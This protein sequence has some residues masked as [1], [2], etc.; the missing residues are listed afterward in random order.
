[1][2]TEVSAC[3]HIGS[4]LEVGNAVRRACGLPRESSRSV[5]LEIED[6][7]EGIRLR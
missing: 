2:R 4:M 3:Y 6:G 1:M 7:V 5:Q